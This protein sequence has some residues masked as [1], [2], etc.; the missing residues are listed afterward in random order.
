MCI[1]AYNDHVTLTSTTV[2]DVPRVFETTSVF[3]PPAQ[4]VESC[5]L[6]AATQG[7][8]TVCSSQRASCLE[9]VEVLHRRA[10]LFGHFPYCS[11]VPSPNSWGPLPT[12]SD[13]ERIGEERSLCKNDKCMWRF[14]KP[15]ESPTV[16]LATVTGSDGVSLFGSVTESETVTTPHWGFLAPMTTTEKSTATKT[17]TYNTSGFKSKKPKSSTHPSST[18]KPVCVD[19]L[20]CREYCDRR[21]KAPKKHMMVLLIAGTTFTAFAFVAMLLKMYGKRIHRWR[22]TRNERRRSAE[23]DAQ[24]LMDGGTVQRL[25]LVQAPSIQ[26]RSRGHVRFQVDGDDM[27]EHSG[28][29]LRRASGHELRF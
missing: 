14:I 26:P 20:D 27:L 2:S 4:V 22:E 1:P 16:R 12:G 9:S 28:H 21:I 17:S 10:K 29:A 13:C 25:Q 19:E 15:W 6:A 23:M 11:T 18:P 7:P 8:P 24:N 3:Y 5:L